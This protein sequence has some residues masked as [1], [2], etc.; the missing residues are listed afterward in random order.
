LGI[1]TEKAERLL[2]GFSPARLDE[3]AVADCAER[4]RKTFAARTLKATGK[5]T[6]L[7]FDWHGFSY[8]FVYALSGEGARAEYRKKERQQG[9]IVL[10]RPAMTEGFSCEAATLPWFEQAR[11]LDLYVV[12]GAFTWTMVF[13]HE[14]DC[15]PY[16]TTAEWAESREPPPIQ[17]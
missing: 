16:F 10:V 7:G 11:M 17:R 4:W 12:S 14:H 6:H 1:V 13:T 15:G 3:R 9:F 5:S 2:A 8:G